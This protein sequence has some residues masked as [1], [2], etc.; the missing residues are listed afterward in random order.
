MQQST[1]RLMNYSF[2]NY[3][4]NKVIKA[5]KD[6]EGLCDVLFVLIHPSRLKYED[7][8]PYLIELQ[9]AIFRFVNTIIKYKRMPKKT[10]IMISYKS[11]QE[12]K[13][14]NLFEVI[15]ADKIE[16]VNDKVLM[17]WWN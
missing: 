14:M 12:E 4:G 16:P 7:V 5:F 17:L 11:G 10:G 15:K 9:K 6:Y 3:N 8:P 1:L 13:L 2:G